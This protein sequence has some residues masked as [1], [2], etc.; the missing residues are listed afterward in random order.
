MNLFDVLTEEQYRVWTMRNIDGLSIRET[1]KA[2][3]LTPQ[4][5]CRLQKLATEKLWNLTDRRTE[6]GDRV[7]GNGAEG[8]EGHGAEVRGTE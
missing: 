2:L 1:A 4:K 6:D 3:G 7:H 8:G 5:V